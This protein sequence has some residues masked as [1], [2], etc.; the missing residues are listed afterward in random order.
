MKCLFWPLTVILSVSLQAGLIVQDYVDAP[1]LYERF[2]TFDANYPIPTTEA[3]FI[4]ADYDLSPIGWGSDGRGATLITPLHAVQSN[5]YQTIAGNIVTFQAM[6]G[7]IVQATV[8]AS[9]RIGG[10]LSLI[11]FTAP[12]SADIRPATV[13]TRSAESIAGAD[14]LVFGK[15]GRVGTN[16]LDYTSGNYAIFDLDDITGEAMAA[17]GDSGS[18]T[19]LTTATGDFELLSIHSYVNQWPNPTTSYDTAIAPFWD[20]IQEKVQLDGYSLVAVPEP[21]LIALLAG[22]VALG[23]VSWRRRRA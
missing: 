20:D 9:E 8:S 14:L 17:M 4:A 2:Q 6:D 3:D 11:T 16:T 5:H 13:S 7:T 10:D 22:L 18:P 23:Y 12:V 21:R 15:G 1:E 19:F